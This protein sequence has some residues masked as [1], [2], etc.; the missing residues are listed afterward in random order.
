M[1]TANELWP[2]KAAGIMDEK[3]I[4]SKELSKAYKQIYFPWDKE[5]D[6]ERQYFSLRVQQRPLFIVVASSLREL[7]S[8]LDYVFQKGLRVRICGGRHSTQMLNPD[9]LVSMSNF[10]S[11]AHIGDVL[12][13]GAGVTQ[14]Q[15]NEYLF[16]EKGLNC[17]SHFGK[18]GNSLFPGGSAQSVGVAGI[19]TVGGIGVLRR[20]FGLTIDSILSFTITLPPA[21]GRSAYTTKV[22]RTV[23]PDLFWALC[24]GGGNNFGIISEITYRLFEVGHVIEYSIQWEYSEAASVMGRWLQGPERPKEYSE[25]LHITRKDGVLGISLTGMYVVPTGLNDLDGFLNV[26][27]TMAYLG[28]ELTVKHTVQYSKLY[29]NMVQERVYSNFSILQGVFTNVIDP[30]YILDSVQNS[31]GDFVIELELMGGQIRDLSG[32]SFGFR[33]SKYFANINCSWDNCSDSY[34]NESWLHAFLKG[35]RSYDGVYL[36][37]PAAFP[38]LVRSNEAYYGDSYPQLCYIK[39]KFDPENVLTYSGTL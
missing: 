15:A 17:Y 30:A 8:V 19:S 31:P 12:T 36:G 1:L 29:N 13:V 37:F 27:D 24:G 4:C 5:Y 18:H 22:S 33:G 23:M 3:G 20:T 26:V 38:N 11:V 28:G 16:C 25:E 2:Q 7:E 39:R 14:G 9:V 32:G 34:L 35:L 21:N 10:S 6:G